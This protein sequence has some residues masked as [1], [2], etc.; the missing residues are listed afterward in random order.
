[1]KKKFFYLFPVALLGL[2]FTLS[3]CGDDDEPE[4]KPETEKGEETIK[5]V[6][7]AGPAVITTTD[8]EML[9]L[10]SNG[11]C[12]FTYDNKGRVVKAYYGGY[13]DYG[14]SFGYEPFKF[15]YLEE[16]ES[17]EGMSV[18][19][20][21]KGYISTCSEKGAEDGMSYTSEMSVD[22]DSDGHLKK[23]VVR[24]TETLEFYGQTYTIHTNAV[25]TFSWEN[26]ALVNVKLEYDEDGEKSIEECKL[27]YGKQRNLYNQYTANLSRW[28]FIDDLAM[29]GFAGEGAAYLPTSLKR[30]YTEYDEEGNVSDT[31]TETYSCSFTQNANGTIATE[32][33]D[34]NTY[35][36]VYTTF[37]ATRSVNSGIVSDAVPASAG[38]GKLYRF[39]KTRRNR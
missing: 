38:K 30:T 39:L 12:D 24:M 19:L 29:V 21:D 4:I 16:G 35:K 25:E 10:T 37:G 26:G 7:S 28:F 2:A 3:S 1:M 36:Y 6:V 11:S 34:G 8:G 22:Y 13:D 17:V 15:S 18:T 5:P 33:S 9:L 14:Y 31:D 32:A 20:N 23:V 27:V